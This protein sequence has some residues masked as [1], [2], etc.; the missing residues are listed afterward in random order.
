MRALLQR[1]SLAKRLVLLVSIPSAFLALGALEVLHQEYLALVR[2]NETALKIELA[3]EASALVHEMQ[4]ERG[5]SAGFLGSKGES[6]RAKLPEQ[7]KNVDEKAK[8]LVAFVESHDLDRVIFADLFKALD[9][10]K[11]REVYRTR[12]SA[13]SISVGDMLNFYTGT[14]RELINTVHKV[15]VSSDDPEVKNMALTYANLIEAKERSGIERAVVSNMFAKGARPDALYE[16]FVRLEEGQKNYFMNYQQSADK[17]YLDEMAELKAGSANSTVLALRQL[18]QSNQT[19]KFKG[20]SSNWWDAASQRINQLKTLEDHIAEKM[21]DVVHHHQS[22]LKFFL[23]GSIA[24]ILLLAVGMFIVIRVIL[25]SVMQPVKAFVTASEKV[26]TAVDGAT[27]EIS[28]MTDQTVA[29]SAKNISL[30]A[31]VAESTKSITAN[32]EGIAA[33]AEELDATVNQAQQHVQKSSKISQE[34]VDKARTAG[35]T[36]ES[37]NEMSSSI[38]DIVKLIN[39]VADQTSLLALNAAIEAA[40]AGDAGRGFAVVA[41]EVKKLAEST[42]KATDQI[43]SQVESIRHISQDVAGI[44]VEVGGVIQDMSEVSVTIN[45]SMNEQLTATNSISESMTQA[46]AKLNDT[47]KDVQSVMEDLETT[48]TAADAAQKEIVNLQASSNSMGEEIKVFLK[49]V[50][51][52]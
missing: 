18:V 27:S 30:G 37:L 22:Q 51:A 47:D 52:N 35:E 14:V 10:L 33:A 28:A 20:E 3:A 12:I 31:N 36:V 45:D 17:K 15:Y 44:I 42:L 1:Y 25:S 50:G 48:K 21:L 7:R 23:W 5:M 2:A 26:L 32:V 24:L 38:G 9:H 29:S 41:E 19:D 11:E 4:K 49:N 34:A 39:D 46:T 8:S 13:L 16:K 6:F 43:T 40:R